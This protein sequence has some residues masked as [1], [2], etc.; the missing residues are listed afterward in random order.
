ME[1]FDVLLRGPVSDYLNNSRAIGSD[2]EKHVSDFTCA[3]VATVCV[4]ISN[5]YKIPPFP[6]KSPPM[7]HEWLVDTHLS[8]HTSW[9]A[10]RHAHATAAVGDRC[11]HSCCR[12]DL[13]LQCSKYV[14]L[15]CARA[16]CNRVLKGKSTNV[17]PHVH[18]N[19]I[20][21]PILL[22]SVFYEP[23]YFKKDLWWFTGAGL[24]LQA[25]KTWAWGNPDV[26]LILW[27]YHF[28]IL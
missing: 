13:R 17:T 15:L 27:I 24:Y 22:K 11:P 10:R 16:T 25:F 12:N 14:Q 19:L 1:A 18:F 20:F 5:V 8:R 6:R 21:N 23:L 7:N 28:D 2:V 4:H 3:T 9:N 26:G